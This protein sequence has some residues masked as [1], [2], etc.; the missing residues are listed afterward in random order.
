M[1]KEEWGNK[2]TGNSIGCATISC[3]KYYTGAKRVL[4]HAKKFLLV[5][6]KVNNNHWNK[7]INNQQINDLRKEASA[8]ETEDEVATEEITANIVLE[9]PKE[10]ESTSTTIY[11]Y[12]KYEAAATFAVVSGDNDEESSEEEEETAR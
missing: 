8:I 6:D 5:P 9:K 12:E 4:Q 7:N 2:Q 10:K 11:Y 1:Q 3:S